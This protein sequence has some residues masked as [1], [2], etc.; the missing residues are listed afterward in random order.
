MAHLLKIVLFQVYGGSPK[1]LSP[2]QSATELDNSSS[3][4]SL[5]SSS[6]QVKNCIL[7]F[8][9]GSLLEYTAGLGAC[10]FRSLVVTK[11]FSPQLAAREEGHLI[12]PDQQI[13][14][15]SPTM[16]K[17][18]RDKVSASAG[19]VAAAAARGAA[20]SMQKLSSEAI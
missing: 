3:P 20:D 12:A 8:N 6:Q 15:T 7:L 9:D 17:N 18:F 14:L 10:R 4:K 13:R 5:H 1:G 19:V 11:G 2:I 16:L